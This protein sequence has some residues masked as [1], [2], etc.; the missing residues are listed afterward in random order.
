MDPRVVVGE[1]HCSSSSSPS[2]EQCSQWL[3]AG[4]GTG[5]PLA[6]PHQLWDLGLRSPFE[7]RFHHLKNGTNSSNYFMRI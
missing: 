3:R 4:A 2:W 7:P 5:H 1:P 6:L